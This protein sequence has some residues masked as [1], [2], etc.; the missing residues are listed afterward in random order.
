LS[1]FYEALT[2]LLAD[3]RIHPLP[4]GERNGRA[5]SERGNKEGA[6]VNGFLSRLRERVAERS[7]GRV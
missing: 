1:E 6:D 4:A 2:R 5:A 7:G 3:A